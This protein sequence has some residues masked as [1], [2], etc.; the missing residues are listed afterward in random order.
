MA[1]SLLPVSA[2]FCVFKTIKRGLTSTFHHIN[3]E[4]SSRVVL[5]GKQ[6]TLRG[7]E[8]RETFL[9]WNHLL[10]GF[11]R[12][13]RNSFFRGAEKQGSNE[14]SSGYFESY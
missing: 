9:Q 6:A 11:Q 2:H 12:N 13:S 14:N 10:Y 1:P 7:Y 4:L 5:L 3:L 8:W